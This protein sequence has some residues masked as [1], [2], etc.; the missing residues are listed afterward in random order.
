M[1]PTVQRLCVLG[2]G[3]NRRPYGLAAV[4]R[5]AWTRPGSTTAVRVS[6]SIS[7]TP[8]RYRLVST[9]TP[10]PTALP[11]MEV[12]APRA[13][14]GTPRDRHTSRVATIS[15]ACRGRTTARGRTRYSEASE[16]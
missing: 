5:E 9:T 8:L 3:P 13:V 10:G 16:E 2:S 1:P 12:P 4:C 6:P 15:S 11:A 14:R 7:R